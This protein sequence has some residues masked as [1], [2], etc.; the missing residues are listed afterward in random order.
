MIMMHQCKF[1]L[2]NK[3]TTLANDADNKGGYVYVGPQG[4]WEILVPPFQ[5]DCEPKTVLKKIKS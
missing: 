4:M 1:I 2:G 3:Y 5:F